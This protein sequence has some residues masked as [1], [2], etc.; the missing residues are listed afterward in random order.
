MHYGFRKGRLLCTR[1]DGR[2]T[3]NKLG[4]QLNFEVRHISEMEEKDISDRRSDLM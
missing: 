4:L 1:K 2:S 3:G